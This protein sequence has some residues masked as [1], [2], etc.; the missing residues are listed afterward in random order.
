MSAQAATRVD[1]HR[2]DVAQ[3]NHQYAL[4]SA[5]LGVAAQA[6]QKH[7]EMLGLDANSALQQLSALRD[8]DGTVHYRYQ[9]TFRGVPIFGEHVVV[10]EDKAGT[11]RNMFGRAVNGLAGELPATTSK[12]ARAQA[13]SIA[14]A[15]ALGS[16]AAASRTEREDAR[17]M[18]YIDDAN[19]AHMS[20]VV[21]FFADSVKGGNPSRPFVIIDANSG[22]V[23]KQWDGL[24]TAL[25]GTGPGGNTKTGQ[26][27]WG[28]GGKYGYLDVA[29]SGTTCTMNNTN[30]KSV[31]LNGGTT[32]TTAYAY[33]CPRNTYKT[34]NGGYAPIN[35][36]HYFGGVITNMYPAYTGYNALTFQLVMRVHYSSAYENAFWDGSTM[37]FGDG[38]STFYPLVSADVAGHEVSHGFTE[39]HSNLTYSGQ[40]GGMNEAFSDMGGEATEYYWK[41]SNDFNVGTEIFKSTGA[42]RY[43]CN[44]TQDGGSIDNAANYTSSLD[45]HYSSGVY[46][47]AF[48][49]LA[50]TAGWSTPTAFKVMARANALYWTPSSTFITGAC[51]VVTAATDLGLSTAD[52]TAAF[53]TVGVSTS[54]CSGGG[55]GGGSTGG[56]L[57]KGVTVT[58]IGASTG[59]TVNYTLVV[60]AG[61]TNLVFTQSGGTGDSDMYVKF[62]SAPTDTVYDCRPYVSGNA[63]TCSFAA[64]SAGTYYVRL[65]AY[66]TFSGVSL[67]GDYTTG[68]TGGTQTYTNSTATSIPD[69]STITST[70][71]VSGRTGNAPTTSKV[72]VNIT[73]TYRGDLKIDLL[74]P[75]GSVYALKASSGSDSADNVVATYTVN[76]STEALNGAWKLRVQDVAAGDVGT[77]NSWSITF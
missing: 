21:S 44:P 14:K 19:H 25:V 62:G 20:Y 58:G 48:C 69:V 54:S 11:V 52:V 76:L 47:K 71:N 40:S 77:L 49:N 53:N 68:G 9:Q 1:L 13:L 72:A 46:N 39:Q 57:T 32:S 63:E 18:I 38:A 51:G 55:G 56:P 73:H 2:L 45:V 30:V 23:L 15:A 65:K 34:I 66:S 12:V 43:M 59:A 50:K 28:S 41:G 33:T 10:S 17:K 42:L 22:R 70:I 31:N 26:Y 36:A 75:D 74:A 4:A 5:T 7:A 8:A 27:E 67:K 29:Q 6:R 24:T 3:V 61:A 35:D 16:R 60:P 37:S 64:P